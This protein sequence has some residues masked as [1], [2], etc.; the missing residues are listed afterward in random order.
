MFFAIIAP[1]PCVFCVIMPRVVGPAVATAI[2]NILFYLWIV[3]SVAGFCRF[4]VTVWWGEW[5]LVFHPHHRDK[6]QPSQDNH[7]FPSLLS[8]LVNIGDLHQIETLFIIER[9]PVKIGA[10]HSELPVCHELSSL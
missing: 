2:I 7:S 3:M 9:A 6:H 4:S 8:H 1:L 10:R 5:M